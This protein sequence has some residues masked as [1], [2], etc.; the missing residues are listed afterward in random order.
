MKKHLSGYFRHVFILAVFGL[1]ASGSAIA[2][3]VEGQV[4]L[5]TL[6]TI[7]KS[8]S[9]GDYRIKVGFKSFD[10]KYR[11]FSMMGEPAEIFSPRYEISQLHFSRPNNGGTINVYVRE[12]VDAKTAYA[13]FEG[14]IHVSQEIMNKAVISS[15]HFSLNLCF[16]LNDNSVQ[17][18]SFD[19]TNPGVLS[20]GG[21]WGFDVAG[22]PSWARFINQYQMGFTSRWLPQNVQWY[23]ESS[24]KS[25]FRAMRKAKARDCNSKVNNLSFD[26]APLWAAMLA[27]DPTIF[28]KL[29]FMSDSDRQMMSLAGQY[30]S[31]VENNAS[32]V[33]RRKRLTERA[34]T[35]LKG[36]L[37][38]FTK[39]I[40]RLAKQGPAKARL[41]K[42]MAAIN[43]KAAR[44]EKLG[45]DA[46]MPVDVKNAFMQFSRRY[47]AEKLR[48]M[49]VSPAILAKIASL[50]QLGRSWQ[51]LEI[52]QQN[53]RL[54]GY[55]DKTTKKIKIQPQFMK[56][57]GFKFGMAHVQTGRRSWGVINA[58]G[59]L[60]FS[61]SYE[62]QKIVNGNFIAIRAGNKKSLFT[63]DG[64][65]FPGLTFD[66][67]TASLSGDMIAVEQGGQWH[68]L[69]GDAKRLTNT[70][71]DSVLFEKEGLAIASNYSRRSGKRCGRYSVY[72]TAW[73]INL[74]GKV[75]KGPYERFHEKS[76][77][78]CLNS[79]K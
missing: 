2:Q 51:N 38:S 77:Q 45:Q 22:S 67:V 56:A 65:Q 76:F 25:T 74:N 66:Y 16:R 41:I 34:Y 29:S 19:R 4:E 62:S 35:M 33:A 14:T 52:F 70:G 13:D 5:S 43:T 64:R 48:Y 47:S 75:V 60:L 78:L 50:L 27:V 36:D 1:S 30:A 59:K 49:G 73:D 58:S 44:L 79:S 10:L 28:N 6:S 7:G 72:H 9:Y 15:L 17:N 71:Y 3:K 20:G 68:V 12:F 11:L 57:R 61:N 37:S 8:Y 54:W 40:W 63:K 46:E 69:N 39:D 42:D 32:N 18:V 31:A 24:A 55:R 23:S 53:Y 26:L 21:K